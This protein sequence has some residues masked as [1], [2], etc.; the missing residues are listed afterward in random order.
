[1]NQPT[2]LVIDDHVSLANAF[3]LVLQR[4]GFQVHV[5]NSA[6]HGLRLAQ[7]HRVNA[8]ILDLR[9]PFI[10]GAGFLYRLRALP[11]HAATPVMVVTGTTIDEEMA[12]E[13]A[14]LG[15]VVR[16]KPLDIAR[17]LSEVDALL[18]A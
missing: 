5:A 16:Y 7:E 2:I 6:E 14:E 4:A 13:L 3:S 15:A 12:S 11:A 1:M 18:A 8:V 17:L 9:M 10:N